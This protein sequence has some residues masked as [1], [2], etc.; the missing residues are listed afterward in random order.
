MPLRSDSVPDKTTITVFVASLVVS[1]I[2][3]IAKAYQKN[4]KERPA[5][6]P[7]FLAGVCGAALFGAV[8]GAAA[9][10]YLSIS[11]TGVMAISGAVAWLGG[12]VFRWVALRLITK[13]FKIESPLTVVDSVTTANS[14]TT[15]N[16]TNQNPPQGGSNP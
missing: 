2:A 16:P 11:F 8:A 4:S 13:Y 10:E 1:I 5:N 7:E 6:F 9:L 14:S 12:D 15:V 3:Y